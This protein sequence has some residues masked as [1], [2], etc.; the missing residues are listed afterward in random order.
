MQNNVIPLTRG[1]LYGS[2]GGY[3]RK[4]IPSD[5]RGMFLFL[6]A[7]LK[8]KEV[9]EDATTLYNSFEYLPC[10]M[11]ENSR[12]AIHLVKEISRSIELTKRYVSEMQGFKTEDALDEWWEAM[13]EKYDLST[14]LKE[15]QDEVKELLDVYYKIDYPKQ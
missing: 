7:L 8:T 12:I 4:E 13:Q 15:L 2:F 3:Y 9:I 10:A 11:E 5:E 6:V 14:M 1:L